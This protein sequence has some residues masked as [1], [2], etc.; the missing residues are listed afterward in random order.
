MIL[1]LG[2]AMKPNAAD[3]TFEQLKVKM[4]TLMI[5]FVAICCVS[6]AAKSAGKWLLTSM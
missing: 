5:L 1:E 4:S 6:F 3:V 2:G